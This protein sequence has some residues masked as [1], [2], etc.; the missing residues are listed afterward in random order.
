MQTLFLLSGARR[1]PAIDAWFSAPNHELRRL[2]Q[3]WFERM[4]ECGP[5][6]RELIHDG[7]PTACV[8]EAAFAYVDAFGAHVNIGFFQGSDL[9]DPAGL[10]QGSG[11]RMRNVKLRWGEEANT[12]AL[13]DLIAQAYQDMRRRRA[14]VD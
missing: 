2:A 4:R 7:H 14:T 3:P 11:K 10:L 9:D 6:V 13:G 1:D 5:D 8:E 12:D